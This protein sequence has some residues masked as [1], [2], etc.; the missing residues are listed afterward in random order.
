[1]HLCPE[2]GGTESLG[3]VF[4]TERTEH[5]EEF[6]RVKSFKDSLSVLGALG[7]YIN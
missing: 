6:D 5:T 2:S 7:G 4:T 1:V 3:F